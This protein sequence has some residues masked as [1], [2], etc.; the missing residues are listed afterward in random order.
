M[1]TIEA[2]MFSV[3]QMS[4]LCQVEVDLSHHLNFLVTY[5]VTEYIL[6]S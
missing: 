6:V 2:V 1:K 5:A 3:G 4:H